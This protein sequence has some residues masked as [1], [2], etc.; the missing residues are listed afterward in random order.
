MTTLWPHQHQK[1]SLVQLLEPPFS[2]TK[3]F[4]FNKELITNIGEACPMYVT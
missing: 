1:N 4:F 3:A 2:Q